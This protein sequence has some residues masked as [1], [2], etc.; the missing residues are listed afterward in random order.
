MGRPG[1]ADRSR[2]EFAAR[3]GLDGAEFAWGDEFTPGG[4]H[5]ANTWQGSFPHENL[6]ENGYEGTLSVMAFSPNGYSV[7]DM[8]GNVWEWTSDWYSP[9][10]EADARKACCLP[11]SP[12]GGREKAGYDPSQPEIKIPRQVLNG[13]S[14]LCAPIYCRRHRPAAR[15]PQPIDTSTSHAG[16]RCV[17]HAGGSK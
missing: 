6:R 17:V 4:R 11:A 15:H 7:Y 16:F 3:G 2:G 13:G 14:H 9:R 8:I 12:R 10:H 5:W 1:S